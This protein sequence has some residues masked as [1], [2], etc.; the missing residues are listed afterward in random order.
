MESLDSNATS[1]DEP[2]DLP[3]PFEE[4]SRELS[5]GYVRMWLENCRMEAYFSKRNRMNFNRDNFASYQLEH[6]FSHKQ[7]GQSREVLSKVRNAVE[8]QKT[9]FQQALADLDDW[10]RIVASDGTEGI[11]MLIKPNE[12]QTL[13][14]YM[15]RKADYFTHVG[16]QTQLGLLGSVSI[17]KV[18]GKMVPKPKFK[19]KTEGKGRT[20][21]KVVTV[22][23]DKVWQLHFDDIRQEDY[24]PDPNGASGVKLYELYEGMLD[25]YRVQQLAE[26]P[27]AIYDKEKVSLLK[28]WGQDDLQEFRKARETGQN[29]YIPMRPRIKIGE[30]WGNIVDNVTGEILAENVVVTLA[31]RS[32]IIRKPTA[33]PLWH[34]RSPIVAAALIEVANSVWGIA[35]MDAGVKHNHSLIEIFNLMLDSAMKAVWGINQIRTECL[36]DPSQVTDGIRWGTN[37]RVNTSLPPGAKVAETVI[38]GDIPAEVFNMFNLL[39]QE[40]LTSMKTNDMRMGAQSMRQVKATEVVASE[41]SLTSEFQGIAKNFEEKKI[42][43]ELELACWTICQNWDLI[44][45]EIFTSLFGKERGEELAQLEPQEVFVGTVNGMKFEVFG[46]SLTLRRQSDFRKWTTLLQIIGGSEVLTE[47]FLAQYSFEKLLGEIMTAIDLNKSKIEVDKTTGASAPTPQA[48]PQP[49]QPGAQGPGQNPAMQQPGGAPGASP[50]QMSQI[51]QPA[52]N[53]QNALAAVFHGAPGGNPMGQ[54][55]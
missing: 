47:A 26:G 34:Q 27:D 28:P 16:N 54:A 25:M 2:L 23:D 22:T 36:D 42:Q 49:G 12:M 48:P 9:I 3:R 24:Y 53:A 21:K 38:T 7:E 11:G 32:T 6:D 51:S 20:Y 39:N 14:N 30:Y 37:L 43:P 19:T 50:N 41:N 44:D 35:M 5:E 45:K 33:N 40:T 46:I 55:R 8:S 15:L 18:G 52:Q 31:N 1:S 17:S 4:G 10:Y 29:Q 13:M